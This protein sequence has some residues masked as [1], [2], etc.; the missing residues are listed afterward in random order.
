MSFGYTPKSP[1]S[2]TATVSGPV[3]IGGLLPGNSGVHTTGTTATNIAPAANT[4]VMYVVNLDTTLTIYY[5]HSSGLTADDNATTGG[6]PI[7]AGAPWAIPSASTVY[8]RSASGSP[9]LAFLQ[10]KTS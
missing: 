6:I 7:L 10:Y 9:K 5:S 2:V 8:F 1:S 3:L 4:A